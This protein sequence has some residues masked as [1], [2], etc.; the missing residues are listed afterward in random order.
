MVVWILDAIIHTAVLGPT[1]A[2]VGVF[3]L[4]ALD[5]LSEGRKVGNLR[6]LLLQHLGVCVGCLQFQ[7]P[8]L[9]LGVSFSRT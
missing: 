2:C 1:Y 9:L 6:K 4:E 5:L 3:P 7:R 8:L